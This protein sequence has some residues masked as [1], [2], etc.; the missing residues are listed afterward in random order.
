MMCVQVWDRRTMQT[1]KPVGVMVGHTEGLTH[2]DPKGDGRYFISNCKDQTIKL[3]DV[4]SMMSEHEYDNL[5]AEPR[6]PSFHWSE[7]FYFNFVACTLVR[8]TVCCLST[9]VRVLLQV[10]LVV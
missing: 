9:L 10:C 4:R 2:L 7:W 8:L 5:P 3:W 1:N 6:V